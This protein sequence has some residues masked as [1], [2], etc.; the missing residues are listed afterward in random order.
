MNIQNKN[1]DISILSPSFLLICFILVF[2]TL[3]VFW[4]V[5]EFSFVNFDDPLYVQDNLHV[6][7][8]LTLKNIK[9]AFTDATGITNFW[10]PLTWLSIII[11]Y[12]L[13]GMNAG[14]YHVTN[15]IIH[16]A[17]CLLVLLV[18]YKMTGALW[19]SAFIAAM[20]A[21]H[22]LH[23]ESI[24][25]VTERKD[26]LSTFFWLLTMWAY[27]FYV[28]SPNIKHY[29]LTLLFFLMGLMSKPMLVTLPF[30]MLLLDYWPL[31]RIQESSKPFGLLHNLAR[32]IPE[33]IF[34][35]IIIIII[36]IAAYITQDKGDAL[37]SITQISFLLRFENIIVSYINYLW[38]TIWPFNLS[39]TYLYPKF[40]PAWK[41][42][43]SLGLIAI[44]SFLTIYYMKTR[45]WLIVGWFWYIG[46][47]VPVIG[48]VVIADQAMADRY[49]Y[50]PHLG[51]FIILTWGIPLLLNQLKY[52]KVILAVTSLCYLLLLAITTTNQLRYWK[53]SKELFQHVI[54]VDEDN[55]LAYNNL[56][57][58]IQ[59]E[60]NLLQAIELFQKSIEIAPQYHSAYNN[61]GVAIESLGKAE[62][63]KTLYRLA[64]KLEPDFKAPYVNLAF[65][66]LH[67]GDPEESIK[68]GMEAIQIDPKFTEAYIIVG[69]SH[70]QLGN[71]KKSIR[72][73]YKAIQIDPRSD[74]AHNRL[75]EAL[76]KTNKLD[77][78]ISHFQTALELKPKDNNYQENLNK[79]ILLQTT[80]NIQIHKILSEL[81]NNQES[82]IAYS[83][84]GNLY[85]RQGK[86]DNAI[87]Y[88]QKVLSTTPEDISTMINIASAYAENNEIEKS[89]F[90]LQKI[91]PILPN[92]S[93][94]FYNVACIYAKQDKSFEANIWLQKA[95]DKG[96]A[97]WELIK[98]DKDLENIRNSNE[99]KKLI[100]KRINRQKM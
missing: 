46:T 72:M 12:E 94:D 21:L 66:L 87:S 41:V 95:I 56:G 48:I 69:D 27:A 77:Q 88:F 9:W 61:L 80:L 47:L 63:A 36:S 90:Y 30:A 24:A 71:L 84:L 86:L 79:V 98:N 42:A 49:T 40:I 7:E 5:S 33:K 65:I 1:N 19:E 100:H 10:A 31:N 14:G 22:P 4:Q 91:I 34:F 57:L 59:N 70:Q 96:Y 58:A 55:Y 82:T 44:I 64:I 15:L 13:Y 32:L 35:F 89:N 97:N 76:L 75:G 45:R 50:V 17:N 60:G 92:K 37:P 62:Q 99:F 78:S 28:E 85:L 38:K 11:D 73:Y 53:N 68:Y 81:K 29:L 74:L 83:K 43:I 39:V 25:W 23:V 18:F 6:K 52:K 93:I 8:G 54:A 67:T 3:G 51:I 2:V 20:F 16:I 26:V